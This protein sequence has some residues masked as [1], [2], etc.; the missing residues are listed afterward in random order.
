MADLNNLPTPHE[1]LGERTDPL[2]AVIAEHALTAPFRKDWFVEIV[3]YAPEEVVRRI[4][5]GSEHSAF[6][7]DRGGSPRSRRRPPLVS[8]R[9]AAPE[10]AVCCLQSQCMP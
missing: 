4:P 10:G 3:R 2:R 9:Q 1:V 8:K 6:R 7:V 5:C